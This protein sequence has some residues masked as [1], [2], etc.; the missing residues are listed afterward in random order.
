MK[1]NESNDLDINFIVSKIMEE[2]SKE[3]VG[4][5]IEGEWENWVDDDWEDSE[6]DSNREWYDEHNNGEAQ[7]VV[8]DMLIDWFQKEFNKNLDDSQIEKIHKILKKEYVED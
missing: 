5:M 2:W 6:F 7:E 1:F 4:E 8:F 3:K